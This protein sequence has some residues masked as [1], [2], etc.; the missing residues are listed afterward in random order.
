MKELGKPHSIRT[1][2]SRIPDWFLY[3][4]GGIARSLSSRASFITLTWAVVRRSWSNSHE[5]GKVSED[6]FWVVILLRD[7]FAYRVVE[8]PKVMAGQCLACLVCHSYSVSGTKS[9]SSVPSARSSQRASLER[10]I[11]PGSRHRLMVKMDIAPAL[12]DHTV[13]QISYVFCVPVA[14]CPGCVTN[15]P[16]PNFSP[17]P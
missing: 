7:L 8:I 12:K 10:P 16:G 5:G 6:C 14:A 4:P 9:D 3:N 15:S 13:Q 11:V 2:K 1:P 17:V